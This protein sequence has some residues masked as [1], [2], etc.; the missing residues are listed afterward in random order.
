MRGD[1][2]VSV[3]VILEYNNYV[4][5]EFTVSNLSIVVC[6]HSSVYR[7]DNTSWC[8]SGRNTAPTKFNRQKARPISYVNNVNVKTLDPDRI[9]SPASCSNVNLVCQSQLTGRKTFV[10]LTII[11]TLSLHIKVNQI[12]FKTTTFSRPCLR[13]SGKADLRQRPAIQL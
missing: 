4:V 13:H 9:Q 8:Y 12:Q 7:P 5:F 2:D 10:Y 3:S 11:V 1:T 6:L